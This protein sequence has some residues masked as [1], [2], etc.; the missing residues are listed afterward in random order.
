MVIGFAHRGAPALCQRENAL[1][2]FRRALAAGANGLESDVW[3]TADGVPVLRHD[4]TLGP[5]WLPWRRR[6]AE[7]RRADLPRWMPTLAELYQDAGR[8]FELS[9]D[10]KGRPAGMSTTAAAEAVL[11]VVRAEGG[12]AALRRLWLCGPLSDL[13]AWRR[14]DGD[15]RLVNSTSA[16][17]VAANG[18]AA[19]YARVLRDAGVDTLNLRTRE[20]TPAR[21]GIVADLHAAG[22]LAFGW[23]AQSTATLRRLLG[24]G[25]DGL[26]SDHLHRLVAVTA[27]P[28][29]RRPLTS[30]G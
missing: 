27:T 4:A 10:L 16:A 3:L 26:Y 19:A 30:D 21:A 1:P 11:A 7:L 13:R 22:I 8:P 18:G 12:Q 9:L 2:A 6:V 15:V 17:E 5:A 20:W 28:R 29:P 23:D 14:L 24:Y 25:L